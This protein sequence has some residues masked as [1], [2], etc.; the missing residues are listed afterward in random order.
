MRKQVLTMLLLLSAVV[1]G[2]APTGYYNDANGK[3]GQA[4]LE[5]LH[6]IIDNH[7]DHGYNALKDGY[8]STDKKP[9]GNV[10]DIYSDVPGGTPPYEFQFG[11][12]C[13][14]Y[15]SEGDCYNRE[16]T[17]PQ[18]WFDKSSPMRNDIIHV[19]PTDGKVNGMRSNYP[20]GEV[21]NPSKTSLNG[22]KLGPNT[23]SG[24]SGTVFEPID[25]YKGDLARIYFYM[26]ARYNDKIAG[27]QHNG[28]ADNVLAGNSYPVYDEWQL[29][30]LLRWHKQ[31]PVSQKEI[32]RN[33]ACEDYQNNRNPFVDHPE[34]VCQVWGGDDCI[35]GG[36]IE[37]P[38][39]I[40]STADVTI[41]MST[42]DYQIIIDYVGANNLPNGS[43]YDDSEYYY[44]ASAHYSNFDIRDGK[45]NDKFS[46]PDAA[47]IEA[48]R[49]VFL[50]AK[51]ASSLVNVDYIVNYATYDGSNATGS[52]TFHCTNANPLTFALGA[53]TEEPVD[54]T[55]ED[56]PSG[57]ALLSFGTD[58]TFDVVTWNIEHFPK[59]DSVSIANVSKAIQAL[60]AEVVA[61]QEVDDVAAFNVLMSNLDGY[62]GYVT[63]SEYGNLAYVYKSDLTV[64]TPYTIYN[65]DW[66]AFP[67]R[68]L[69]LEL[70]YNDEDFVIISNH[71]KCCGDG[72]LDEGNTEDEEY[73][74]Q[75]A[76]QKLKAYIDENLSDRSVLVV[77]DFNDEISDDVS[78]N[79]FQSIIDDTENYVF[80]DMP[81]ATGASEN[82]SYP[83]WPSHLDHILVTNELFDRYSC[84]TIKAD[85]L[86]DSWNVYDTN[87]SDHRPVGIR[88]AANEQGGEPDE[89]LTSLNLTFD[90]GLDN[91]TVVQPTGTTAWN[92]TAYN[93]NG[94]AVINTYEN[95][96]NESWLVTPAVNMDAISNRAFSFSMTSYN[97]NKTVGECG[98][99]QFEVYYTATFDGSTIDKSN[100]TRFTSVDNVQLGD[101]SWVW[102]DVDLDVSAI[103][104]EAIYFAFVHKSDATNGTTWELDNVL[105]TGNV[106]RVEE[107]SKADR[108]AVY[109][110]PAHQ[111]ISL[112][113]EAHLVEVCSL[114][115]RTVIKM[116][117][118]KAHQAINI[119]TLQPGIYIVKI[120]DTVTKVAVR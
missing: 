87:V 69:V 103:T 83:S 62:T 44:G 33:D 51:V 90:N 107:Y 61:I 111:T 20:Y 47:I 116:Q 34:W 119:S 82:W 67:R 95:G 59:N 98:E 93:E 18:S 39:P 6:D 52:K 101:E 88:I 48:L 71:F 120:D 29:E 45:C 49:D 86:L 13:G 11:N 14:T 7:N 41:N 53:A 5:A 97:S 16:H 2:A 110:N 106:T 91:C 55:I 85:S 8:R 118:V 10:W 38:E 31:D 4:L 100:W 21:S 102:V 42:S 27:W 73:R 58:N 28:T 68:P 112:T 104:G 117:E 35:G 24:Y 37:E 65:D 84:K 19:L 77:G 50:P 75:Q 40:D 99:G 9:N 105:L 1:W 15:Q 70:T 46:S 30:L 81:I 32:N 78:N 66:S 54:S 64:T 76:S 109:P 43:T 89:A 115:G 12:T 36:T 22:S 72:I 92:Q 26:A 25:E 3:T 57:L 108:I 23:T 56:V 60:N 17:F 74:R 80:A 79:V 114:S 63:G 113:E 94:Y 96:A